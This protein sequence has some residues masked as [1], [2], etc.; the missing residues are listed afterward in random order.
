MLKKHIL[1]SVYGVIIVPLTLNNPSI[2]R[3][4]SFLSFAALSV[5]PPMAG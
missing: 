2:I 3:Y 1:P 5:Q 4:E